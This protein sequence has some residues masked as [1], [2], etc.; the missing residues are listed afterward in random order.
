L[1]KIYLG[2]KLL[3]KNI[4]IFYKMGKERILIKTLKDLKDF[5]KICV[6]NG[7]KYEKLN[8]NI[9]VVDKDYIELVNDFCMI[10]VSVD[11]NMRDRAKDLGIF[12]YKDLR[13]N[14]I[15]KKDLENEKL[16]NFIELNKR[17]KFYYKVPYNFSNDMKDLG[18]KFDMDK[19]M[20]FSYEMLEEVEDYFIEI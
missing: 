9:F 5:K 6:D 7:V 19:K 3:K 8:E 10:E 13:K 11:E 17:Q 1:N 15:T 2:K 12:Y 4:H 14:F 20:W 16:K 18:C